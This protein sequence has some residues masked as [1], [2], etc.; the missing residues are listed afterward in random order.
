[1]R[2]LLSIIMTLVCAFS[3]EA[4]TNVS[5]PKW[6]KHL[7]IAPRNAMYYYRITTAEA[8]TYDEAYAKAFERAIQESYWKLGVAVDIN[9]SEDKQA[10]D[11]VNNINVKPSQVRLKLN[12]VCEHIVKSTINMNV[13]VF[14]LWQVACYG[15]VDPKFDDFTDCE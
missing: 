3:S 8:R 9:T 1:M 15:N 7:P 13:H 2:F 5:N 11:I 10:Q 4:Q 14:I 12:K 6:L